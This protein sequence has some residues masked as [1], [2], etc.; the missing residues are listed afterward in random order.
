MINKYQS[1]DWFKTL[2][3]DSTFQIKLDRCWE[4]WLVAAH[5]SL[6]SWR[7]PPSLPSHSRYRPSS[8]V[9]RLTWCLMSV[10]ILRCPPARGGAW[11]LRGVRGR[12]GGGHQ[13]QLRLPRPQP[14][15]E[16]GAHT[17]K[18][19]YIEIQR[20]ILPTIDL[21]KYV[22][23]IIFRFSMLQTRTAFMLIPRC[24]PWPVPCPIP[25]WVKINIHG[26][27]VL[28]KRDD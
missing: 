21:I 11:P 15:V 6:K 24:S 26:N 2:R 10:R 20:Y 25:M 13:G 4:S 22:D 1:Y 16:T 27:F 17:D 28:M 8:M 14:G 19:E 3:C 18:E 23:C 9:T 5:P 12:R 7:P